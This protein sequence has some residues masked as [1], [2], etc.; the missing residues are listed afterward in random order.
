MKKNL[1][2]LAIG[3]L[4]VAILA[5]GMLIVPAPPGMTGHYNNGNNLVGALFFSYARFGLVL[6]PLVALAMYAMYA[7]ATIHRK[8]QRGLWLFV[9]H[10]VCAV[11]LVMPF[12]VWRNPHL[13]TDSLAQLSR[14]QAQP[15]AFAFSV[16]PFVLANGLFLWRV[17]G[18][19]PAQGD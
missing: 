16:L 4:M 17:S 1:I 9:L 13:L 8:R 18:R 19:R 7:H 5:L 14:L 10:Y 6:S 11:G 2:A 3:A 12:E 15:G